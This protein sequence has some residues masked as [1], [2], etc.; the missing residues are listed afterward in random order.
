MCQ[1][2]FFKETCGSQR[3]K[4]YS[5][6]ELSRIISVSRQTIVRWEA[7]DTYPDVVLLKKLASA[8]NTSVAYLMGETDDPSPIP[9]FVREKTVLDN[10]KKEPESPDTSPQKRTPA[11]IIKQIADINDALDQEAPFFEEED[12]DI[13]QTY[14]SDVRKRLRK[15]VPSVQK[16][17]KRR[18]NHTLSI[19]VS[20]K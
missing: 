19:Q 8:L 4:K 10:A 20:L 16:N 12:I 6:V 1:K 18:H 3:F 17:Q 5:Q 13:A 2:Y 9:T 7:N 11:S 15:K 14:S